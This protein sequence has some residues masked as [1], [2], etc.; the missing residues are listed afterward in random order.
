MRLTRS[1]VGD[2]V[3]AVVLAVIGV[4]G[5]VFADHGREMGT[6]LDGL[7]VSLVVAAALALVVRRRWPA[8]VLIA[9]A[10]LTS[11]YLVIGY[12][13]GP[14]LL[15][16]LVAVYT[17]ASH[18]PLRPSLIYS[19][20]ALAVM[21]AHI[22]TNEDAPGIVGVI[23]GSAW[24]VVPYA[25][26]LVR[27]MRREAVAR[28]RTEMIRQHVDE[29][30]LRVAQEVH[31]I[32]GHGLAA[33]KMQADIALHLLDKK[34]EQARP[35]LDAISRT[36]GAALE[37]LRATLA[38]VRRPG[39]DAGERTPGP[40]LDR[41]GELTE[42]MREA[43]L[44]VKVGVEGQPRELPAIVDLTGYRIVQESLTNVL[45]HGGS[46]HAEVMLG[47][48]EDSMGIRVSNRVLGPPG[49]GGGGMGIRGMRERVLALGGQFEAGMGENGIFEVRVDI[50]VGG[51]Q[52]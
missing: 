48:A 21:M 38:A 10:L 47:Y 50:P 5:T 18:L 23:P 7:G 37:E 33:I 49:K 20:V 1:Q 46:R 40:R 14:I 4:A 11:T 16:F 31:D 22:F 2:A 13:Y 15:S 3:L 19:G 8:A 26:G 29:E 12:T 43:G 28:D 35:A 36:S 42:R 6:A 44:D 51:E 17:V 32:V 25:A 39:D 30:R 9:V 34:P 24:V 45:R 41:L 27:R 52:Q